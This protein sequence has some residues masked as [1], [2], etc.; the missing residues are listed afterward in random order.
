M[1]IGGLPSGLWL[2]LDA[3][4]Q[5]G[6]GAGQARAVAAGAWAAL[7]GD[8]LAYL[9][10]RGWTGGGE[11]S[12]PWSRAIR[13]AVR[14]DVDLAARALLAVRGLAEYRHA[15]GCLGIGLVAGHRVGREGVD[16]TVS[17]GVAPPVR[18]AR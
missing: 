15:C 5:A 2:R 9:D 8:D 13:T 3:A 6:A 1:R 10:A 16:V 14:G 12:V 17:V 11:L 7:P 4:A 18:V